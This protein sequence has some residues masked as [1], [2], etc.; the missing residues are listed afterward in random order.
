MIFRM[1]IETQALNWFG[2]TIK[3]RGMSPW[4]GINKSDPGE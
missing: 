2:I 3:Q 4:V 1:G